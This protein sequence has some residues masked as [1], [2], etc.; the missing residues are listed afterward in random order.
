MIRSGQS[1]GAQTPAGRWHEVWFY[2]GTDEF[3]A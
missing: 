1:A 2:R 3:V